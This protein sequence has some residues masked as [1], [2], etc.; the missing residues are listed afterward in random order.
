M[1]AI[2]R[3]PTLAV[4][5]LLAPGTAY[6][7]NLGGV[8]GPVVN[9]GHRSAQ[10][11]VS[12]IPDTDATGHRA[13]YQHAFNDDFMLRTT[14]Q[15]RKTTD[16]DIDFDFIEAELF[17]D[18]G[19]DGDSYRTGLRFDARVRSDGRPGGVGVNWIHQWRPAPDWTT[20]FILLT[21]A[22]VGD[23]ARDGVFLG[24]R[25]LASYSGFQS[26]SLGVEMYSGYGSTDDFRDVDDQTHQLGPT[27]TFSLPDGFGLYANV[28]LGLTDATPDEEFR[29][30]VM[31]AF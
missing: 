17:W 9:E 8:F 24:T 31:K 18:L 26:A 19:A 3:F 15:A 5:T 7:Q 2:R 16:S 10:Y 29:L 30:R 13:W 12:H 27:I 20:R 14:V 21:S 4:L 11:R 23:N 22:D 1:K 6:A 25:A 28:L